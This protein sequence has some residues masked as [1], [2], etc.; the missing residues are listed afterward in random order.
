MKKNLLSLF[1]FLLTFS[2]YAEDLAI[3]PSNQFLYYHKGYEKRMCES[4]DIVQREIAQVFPRWNTS[5]ENFNMITPIKSGTNLLCKTLSLM[6]RRGHTGLL[7][8]IVRNHLDGNDLFKTNHF[9]S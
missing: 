2:V 3:V 7:G 1:F 4:Y 6:T 5:M 8:L 9:F